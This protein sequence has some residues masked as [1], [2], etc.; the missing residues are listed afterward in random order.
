M[1]SRAF[2][3]LGVVSMSAGCAHWQK[4]TGTPAAV[5]EEHPDRIAHLLIVM[6]ART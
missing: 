4:K 1:C 5:L 3:I 6:S 2:L